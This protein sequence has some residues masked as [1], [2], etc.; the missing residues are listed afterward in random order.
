MQ[1]YRVVYHRI[2]YQSLVFSRYTHKPLTNLYH[3]YRKYILRY[4]PWHD[5][6]ALCSIFIDI[7]GILLMLWILN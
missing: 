5:I 1:D 4:F 2:S 7:Q 3:G 6:K